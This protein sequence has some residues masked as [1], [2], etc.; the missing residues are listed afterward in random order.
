MVNG[1]DSKNQGSLGEVTLSPW[2]AT[3]CPLNLDILAN[4]QSKVSNLLQL[5]KLSYPAI[6]HLSPLSNVSIVVVIVIVQI[7]SVQL[8]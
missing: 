8:F 7:E 6:Y 4:E 2:P 5:P 1:D 3:K